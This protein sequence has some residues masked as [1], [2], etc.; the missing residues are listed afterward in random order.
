ME[1]DVTDEVMLFCE[2]CFYSPTIIPYWTHLGHSFKITIEKTF[3]FVDNDNKLQLNYAVVITALL[4]N[5]SHRFIFW[6]IHPNNSCVFL[7]SLTTQIKGD[8]VQTVRN[9]D[10]IQNMFTYCNNITNMFSWSIHCLQGFPNYSNYLL[11]IPAVA[12]L[13]YIHRE[14]VK[15]TRKLCKVGMR[16]QVFDDPFSRDE[17]TVYFSILGTPFLKMCDISNRNFLSHLEDK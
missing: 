13:H 8:K 12:T 3:I 17:N 16:G 14:H 2:N 15:S 5:F 4:P 6:M 10:C 1:I 9:S 7:F 11:T